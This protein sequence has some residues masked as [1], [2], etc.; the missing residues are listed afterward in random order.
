MYKLRDLTVTACLGCDSAEDIP[1]H[2]GVAFTLQYGIILER[3][4][5]A[6]VERYGTQFVRSY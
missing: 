3:S 1:K 6:C 5:V 2:H 4:E